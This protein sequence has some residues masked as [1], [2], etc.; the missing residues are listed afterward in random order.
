M[1]A[2]LHGAGGSPDVPLLTGEPKA[3][4]EPQCR[5]RVVM[6]RVGQVTQAG[7]TAGDTPLVA[8]RVKQS[9]GFVEE[10]LSLIVFAL[11]QARSSQGSQCFSDATLVA[12]L[13]P[14]AQTLR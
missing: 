7:H 8:Q 12:H 14:Q 13:A 6:T 10:R 1:P 4:L 5:L 11:V 3:V 9:E 2:R